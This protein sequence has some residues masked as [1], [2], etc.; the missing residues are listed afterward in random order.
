MRILT[1]FDENMKEKKLNRCRRQEKYEDIICETQWQ[2]WSSMGGNGLNTY[3]SFT[4]VVVDTRTTLIFKYRLRKTKNINI[5]SFFDHVIISK[6]NFLC[7]SR[8]NDV[9]LFILSRVFT[10]V[11]TILFVSTIGSSTANLRPIYPCH[12][13]DVNQRTF[14]CDMCACLSSSLTFSTSNLCSS[15]SPSVSSLCSNQSMKASHEEILRSRLNE[16]EAESGHQAFSQPSTPSR[17]PSNDLQFELDHFNH[18]IWN[19]FIQS[20]ETCSAVN[21]SRI[22]FYRLQ[23][24][25]SANLFKQCSLSLLS[26]RFLDTTIDNNLLHLQS[27]PETLIFYN[28]TFYSNTLNLTSSTT[29]LSLYYTKFPQQAFQLNSLSSLIY[30]TISHTTNF[31]LQGAFP[32]LIYLDLC[33]SQLNDQELN[34]MFSQIDMPDLMTLILANNQ[35]TVLKTRFPS[36]IRYLDLS[37]N[38]IKSLDYISFKSLYSLNTLNLSYNSLLDIQQDT[39]TRIPYL[40]VLDLTACLPSSPI[41]DLFL[42]LQKLRYLNIS[43]NHLQSLPRLPIPYDAHTIASYDHH[44]P[45]L[46]VDMSKNKLDRIDFDLLS[47]ASTQDKYIISIDMNF[48]QLKT[49]QL[50]SSSSTGIRRRGPLIE[51]N[52]HNNPLECDCVLYENIAPLLKTEPV[53]QGKFLER[54]TGW[55]LLFFLPRWDCYSGES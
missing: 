12:Y 45:V 2:V 46:Y 28:C 35:I 51:L 5:Q 21:Q 29:T 40:E 34:R 48:N 19:N 9:D 33:H 47:S 53:F 1:P 26:L 24:N 15:F 14:K 11:M 27:H 36:T 20:E 16:I 13:S 6:T 38:Q 30:L 10:T 50:P 52:I 23:S 41:D 8:M 17:K 4:C 44:L 31:D 18:E 49:I 39:F 3:A 37:Y 42:P 32:N 54:I 55:A 22:T 43:S 25:G 7:F